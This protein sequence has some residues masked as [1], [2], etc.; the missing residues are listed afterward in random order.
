MRRARG[1]LVSIFHDPYPQAR[2]HTHPSTQE[3]LQ[4]CKASLGTCHVQGPVLPA[5][6]REVNRGEKLQSAF[7]AAIFPAHGNSPISW[8]TLSAGHSWKHST[9]RKGEAEADEKQVILAFRGSQDRFLLEG[10]GKIPTTSRVKNDTNK[11]P[12]SGPS[13]FVE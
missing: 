8:L 5:S 3:T 12:H 9:N 1:F 4:D 7:G 2:T 6:Y 10:Q 13:P 11:S